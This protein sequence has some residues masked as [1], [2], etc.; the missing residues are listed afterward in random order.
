MLLLAPEEAFTPPAAKFVHVSDENRNDDE[1]RRI[2]ENFPRV[3]EAFVFR[4]LQMI[5]LLSDEWNKIKTR[6]HQSYSAIRNMN[7]KY[8]LTDYAFLDLVYKI[9]VS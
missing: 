7:M 2:G 1:F 3:C 4:V 5:A 6:V 8:C 9:A